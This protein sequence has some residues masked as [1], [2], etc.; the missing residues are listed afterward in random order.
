MFIFRNKWLIPSWYSSAEHQAELVFFLD[1]NHKQTSW[2]IT[3]LVTTVPTESMLLTNFWNQG[4]IKNILFTI[5]PLTITTSI[6][7]CR[8][9]VTTEHW[10]MI[11]LNKLNAL[12]Q[13]NTQKHHTFSFNHVKKIV[14]HHYKRKVTY[15]YTV[16]T[17]GHWRENI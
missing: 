8:Y 7:S 17:K 2:K 13:E 4:Q 10:L 16:K 11:T 15:I 6:F 14:F 12:K 1:T 3:L 9:F 5:L